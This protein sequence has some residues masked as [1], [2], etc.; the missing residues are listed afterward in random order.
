M[1]GGSL[2]KQTQADFSAGMFRGVDPAQISTSGALDIEGLLTA[3]GDVLQRGGTQLLSDTA[4][5]NLYGVWSGMVGTNFRQVLFAAAGVYRLDPDGSVNL[6]EFAPP[7]ARPCFYGS[8]LLWGQIRYDG[9]ATFPGY[10]PA[11]AT[12]DRH[13]VTA[14]GKL[15][16][17]YDDPVAGGTVVAFTAAGSTVFAATDFHRLDGDLRGIYPLRN[18]VAVFTTRG[19]FVI[20]GVENELTD[21]NGNI[22]HRI[23]L[24]S[25]DVV[26]WGSSW[27]ICGYEGGIIVPAEGAVWSVSLGVTSE[28]ALPLQ[29]IS[30]PIAGMLRDANAI[31]HDGGQAEVVHGHYLLPVTQ[32]GV[33]GVLVEPFVLVCRLD[34]DRRGR[35]F[36]WSRLTGYGAEMRAVG[37]LR[38]AAGDLQL[39]GGSWRPA[40]R[41]V[42]CGWFERAVIADSNG[43]V[44]VARV[45]T[46]DVATGPLTASRV[47]KVRAGYVVVD[48]TVTAEAS[49]EHGE[50]GPENVGVPLEAL[51]GVGDETTDTKTFPVQMRGRFVRVAVS[52]SSQVLPAV[53]RS[54]EIFVLTSGRQ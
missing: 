38:D 6:I 14:A 42:T 26:L 19:L 28:A 12:G 4:V 11:A 7:R 23:D 53:I 15:F 21:A 18:A 47:V 24:Y 10:G 35:R 50:P 22:L 52:A 40:R 25:D 9:T 54:I 51:D 17:A 49:V 31:S 34:A 37:Y 41:L 46:R 8:E 36:A 43:D 5:E 13:F 20:S 27:G 48:G 29:K 2:D 32:A 39:V 45:V 30:E 3:E 16:C 33:G 44:P 1:A